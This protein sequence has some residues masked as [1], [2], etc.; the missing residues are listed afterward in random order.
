L[1]QVQVFLLETFLTPCFQRFT[2]IRLFCFRQEEGDQKPAK[3]AASAFPA[4]A[5]CHPGS[6]TTMPSE[7]I[8]FRGDKQTLVDKRKR[9]IGEAVPLS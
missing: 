3:L 6:G 8:K 4:M 7:R 1:H 2:V 5:G 9:A